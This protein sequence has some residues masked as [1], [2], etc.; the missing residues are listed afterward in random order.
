MSLLQRCFTADTKF[1]TSFLTIAISIVTYGADR[2]FFFL[3][4]FGS[5]LSLLSSFNRELISK[6]IRRTSIG[7]E[8]FIFLNIMKPKFLFLIVLIE[9]FARKFGH[10][11]ARQNTAQRC[12]KRTFGWRTSDSKRLCSSSLLKCWII[13]TCKTFYLHFS[14]SLLISQTWVR[15]KALEFV[16]S[17]SR[18]SSYPLGFLHLQI[19]VM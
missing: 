12:K 1:L 9:P 8:T 14:F 7:R 15:R 10:H 18:A 11:T 3:F 16:V 19:I 4:N 5:T 6:G 13:S 2:T 17:R